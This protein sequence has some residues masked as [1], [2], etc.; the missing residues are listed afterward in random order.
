MADEED[1]KHAL[2]EF[3]TALTVR[4]NVVGTGIQ[5]LK[6]G[7]SEAIAVYVSEKVPKEALAPEDVIPESVDVLRRGLR[8]KVPIMVID[9]GGEF[10]TE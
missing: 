3:E 9:V 6:D 2:E 4:K 10:T 8:V 1:V 7:S 5:P